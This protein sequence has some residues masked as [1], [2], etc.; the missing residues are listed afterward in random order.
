M[1]LR[2]VDLADPD[3]FTDG[4]TPWG[5]FDILRREA[6]VYWN[7]DRLHG[8][9]FWAVTR[10]TDVYRI[11]RDPEL[12][13]SAR[14]GVHLEDLDDEQ[15]R[16][17][18]SMIE[19]DGSRHRALRHLLQ[20]DFS[21]AALRAHAPTVRAMVRQAFDDLPE[22]ETVDAVTRIS[23][24]IPLRVLAYLLGIPDEHIPMI[25]SWTSQMLGPVDAPDGEG[26]EEGRLDVDRR[27]LPY[28]RPAAYEAI[29]YGRALAEQR[30]RHPG[31]DL[32]SRLL[33]RIPADGALLTDVDYDNYFILLLTSGHET[34]RHAITHVLHA[35]SERPHLLSTL[36]ARPD[37][38]PAA[39]EEFLRWSSPVY[40]FRRTATRD[41]ELH[42]QR[43][44]AGDRVVIWLASANRD[45]AV[46]PEADEV[47]FDRPYRGHV[48]FGRGSRHVCLGA[49]LARLELTIFLQEAVKRIESVG[50]AGKARWLR[51]N[52]LHGM[53]SLPLDIARQ[54]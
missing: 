26:L 45:P 5:M 14:R 23:D 30:R 39:V 46:F 33:F 53:T 1:D 9:G 47:R 20:A 22:H 18:R 4:R 17:R 32:I 51:S 29:A 44:S 25:L 21:P 40:H 10:Y 31:D 24:R 7:R 52:F 11:N 8:G 35:M 34:T 27:L 19:T 36:R 13:S 3:N 50:A 49:A 38:I 43:I 6:P 15:L 28:G 37:R 12:F 42:G 2:Q 16:A 48:A 41:V 54:N